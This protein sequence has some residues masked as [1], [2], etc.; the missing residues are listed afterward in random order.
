MVAA[1][2]TDHLFGHNAGMSRDNYGSREAIWEDEN[3]AAAI[4]GESG[5]SVTNVERTPV[6]CLSAQ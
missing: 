2:Q 5:S 3:N 1:G 4:H 6:G